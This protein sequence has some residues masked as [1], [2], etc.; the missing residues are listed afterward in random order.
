MKNAQNK[1]SSYIKDLIT[2]VFLSVILLFSCATKLYKRA[3]LEELTK[4]EYPPEYEEIIQPLTLEL[5]AILKELFF[6]NADIAKMKDQLWDGGSNHRIMRINDN[7]DITKEEIGKLN[8]MRRE[9]LNTIDM[10]IPDFKEPV[11]VGYKGEKK[12][13]EKIKKKTIILASLEDQMVYN[14]T[15][16]NGDKLSQD[17]S[18][19]EIIDSALA[20][21]NSIQKKKKLELTRI[22]EKGPVKKIQKKN[23]TGG[24]KFLP[25]Y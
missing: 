24:R 10:I 20:D 6:L 15:K 11:V 5:S 7:I 12:R 9:I 14:A 18:Y 19:K 4:I 17:L 13:Y 1:Y 23:D 3:E 2:P 25:E 8:K 22:G 16:A 21:F